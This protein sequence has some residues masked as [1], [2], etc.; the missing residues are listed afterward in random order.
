MK[1]LRMLI[2]DDEMLIL[3]GLQ[4]TYDWESLGFEVVGTALDGDEVLPL[5]EELCPDIILTDIRMKRMGGLE[6]MEQMKAL[7]PD[8]AFVV[9]SAYKDFEYARQA[10][11][12]GALSYL[13]KPINDEELE[14]NMSE[15]YKKCSS[16]L[17]EKTVLERWRKLLMQDKDNFLHIMTE[18]YL[19]NGITAGEIENLY[20]ELGE[21]DYLEGYFLCICADMDTSYR[22]INQEDFAAKRHILGKM[23]H[24]ALKKKYR[25]E[26][27]YNE[28]GSFL[29]VV[30]AG[31]ALGQIPFKQL[32]WTM[33]QELGVEI[34]S[35]ISNC[36]QG[37]E[38]MKNAYMEANQL[39]EIACEAGASALTASVTKTN[40]PALPYSIDIENQILQAV[41]EASAD[42]MKE[43]FRRFVYELNEEEGK[44]FLHR[45]MVRIEYFL[46]STGNMTEENR[47]S[48][49]NF[50]SILYRFSVVRTVDI[51]YRLLTEIIEQRNTSVSQMS[52][53]VFREYVEQALKYIDEHLEDGE[54]SVS[55][56]ADE[57]HL[58]S[59]YFGRVFKAVMKVSFKKYVLNRRIELA[60]TL[61]AENRYNVTQVGR[62]VGISNSS[63][64]G[65]L[66]KEVTGELPSAY[67]GKENNEQKV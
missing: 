58:N 33:Q 53:N 59:A 11:R 21:Y 8:I 42:K 35:S 61:L 12:N 37:P 56:V 32:L 63:Y 49:E 66:F 28:D 24:D 27:F 38:G 65:K 39:Y 1:V 2:V 40:K 41:R 43:A 30:R 22:V 48:F 9:L 55:D 52:E 29:F 60:K 3:R 6:L 36:W 15:V 7:H 23:L 64:F 57:I 5:V 31:E 44:I 26:C 18:R 54:L 14:K 13:V 51:A 16:R 25:A 67:A 20:H 10:I 34:V 46:Q 17:H 47:S 45:L 4:E 50:Y 19:K 62:M